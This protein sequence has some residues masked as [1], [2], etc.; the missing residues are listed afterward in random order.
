MSDTTDSIDPTGSTD[1]SLAAAE[2]SAPPE[3]PV[4]APEPAK[5]GAAVGSAE[6]NLEA[7]L[8]VPVALSIEVGR[9]RMRLDDLLDTEEGTVIELDKLLNE[10]LD[11]LVN[12]AL[13]AHGVI[14]LAQDRFGIQITDILSPEERA[15]T[16]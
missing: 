12:G 5:P 6:V 2:N 10:P 1:P 7:L 16:L 14:V 11:I 8:K 3:Q 9:R 4:A 15:R 13:I